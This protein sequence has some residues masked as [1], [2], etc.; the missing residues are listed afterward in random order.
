MAD[1]L[2]VDD[3][4]NFRKMLKHILLSRF[5]AMHIREAQDADAA[6]QNTETLVPDLIFMDMR[7]PGANGIQLTKKIKAANP[8]VIIIMITN[9]DTPEYRE[10]ALESGADFFVSKKASTAEDVLAQVESIFPL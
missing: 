4:T 10:A 5:P 3:N 1:I 7:L 2:I 8:G 6:L 9:Y